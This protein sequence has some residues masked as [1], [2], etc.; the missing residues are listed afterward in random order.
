MSL[1]PSEKGNKTSKGVWQDYV[2]IYELPNQRL[3]D[4]VLRTTRKWVDAL[5]NFAQY[6]VRRLQKIGILCE[7]SSTINPIPDGFHISIS[8]KIKG[9]REN[10]LKKHLRE[11]SR[12]A[13][14]RT[15]SS[16]EYRKHEPG[17]KDE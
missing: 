16:K 12:T 10:L 8:I 15:I 11:A 3:R 13:N 4:L 6:I 17:I 2:S 9:I 14:D 5:E 1:L 7:F